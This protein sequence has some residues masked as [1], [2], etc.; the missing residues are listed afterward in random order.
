MPRPCVTLDLSHDEGTDLRTALR[1]LLALERDGG[2]P[3]EVPTYVSRLERILQR[4]DSGL[5]YAERLRR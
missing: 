3:D 5:A 1:D 4:L 2:L